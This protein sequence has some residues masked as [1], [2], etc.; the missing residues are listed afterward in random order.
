MMVHIYDTMN[1]L[2]IDLVPAL[3]DEYQEWLD[4]FDGDPVGPDLVYADLVRHFHAAFEA[5][6]DA[7][8]FVPIFAFI[9]ELAQHTDELVLS[10]VYVTVV[11]GL[12]DTHDED[13]LK[14]TIQL[15]GPST[16]QITYEVAATRRHCE[17][18]R[19]LLSQ[20]ADEPRNV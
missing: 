11:E 5:G 7:A 19:R 17:Q 15:M 12:L 6:N 9:E 3:T 16:R 2:L 20:I 18:I 10:V 13:V 8:Y 1:E 14:R 4:D